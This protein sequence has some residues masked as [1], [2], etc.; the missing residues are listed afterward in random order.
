MAR[1]EGALV[2]DVDGNVFLDFAAGIAVNSPPATPT[3]RWSAPSPSRRGSSCT[4]RAP[5][6]TTSRRCGSPSGWRTIAP[7]AGP[8]QV[9]L[10]QLRRRGRRGGDQAGALPHRPRQRHRV[11]RRVP[12]AHAGRAVADGEQGGA[13]PRLRAAGARRVP[14]AV[15][16]L[17]SL[18]GRAE[19]GE[20]RGRV[21]RVHRGPAARAP[22]LARRGRRHRR[23]AD[24]GRGR[25][26]RAA[27]A[28][29]PAAAGAHRAPRHPAGRRRGA[30]RHGPHRQDVRHRALRRASP[31]SWRWPRASPRACRSA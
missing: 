17:L 24:P 22:R 28:V 21:P 20:L 27:G 5:T 19:A 7:I 29:P 26:H 4:C 15:R 12:R 3:P 31:T 14:R 2:E 9:V 16:R 13:A 6:S 30:D 23:R 11:P 25:L 18:P 8:V 10:R 1:G